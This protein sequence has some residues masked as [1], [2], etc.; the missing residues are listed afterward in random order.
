M[1]N[2]ML[3]SIS[4]TMQ[5]YDFPSMN[6]IVQ[7]WY[8]EPELNDA[9]GISDGSDV[10]VDKKQSIDNSF[11]AGAVTAFAALGIFVIAALVLG[12]FRMRRRQPDGVSTL[13][14]GSYLTTQTNNEYTLKQTPFSTMLPNSYKLDEPDT[15]S[16]I[17]E[18]DYDSDKCQNS[19]I[20]SD[21]GYT[22]DGGAQKI[23]EENMETDRELLFDNDDISSMGKSILTGVSFDPNREEFTERDLSNHRKQN[24]VSGADVSLGGRHSSVDVHECKSANC[25]IC[26]Y[27]PKDVNFI[28]DHCDSPDVSAGC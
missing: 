18:G 12:I 3:Y 28:R 19:V 22:S 23:D 24:L 21:G 14:P 16:C 4:N 27:Q 1:G 9:S 15:M 5:R 13:G 2:D 7:T 6:K 26:Q 20:V 25:K 8:L 10:I 17:M 11:S